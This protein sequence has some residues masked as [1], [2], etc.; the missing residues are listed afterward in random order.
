MTYNE[1]I[2][3]SI[4]KWRA[5]NRDAYNLLSKNRKIKTGSNKIYREKVKY[6]SYTVEAKRQ[7]KIL[8]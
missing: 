4:M 7:C 2:Y 3:I 8:M 6:F 5:K 1:G